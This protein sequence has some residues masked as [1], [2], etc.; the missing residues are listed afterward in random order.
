MASRLT[1][2]LPDP[3]FWRGRKVLVTGHTGFKGAW[4]AF[5]LQRLGAQVTGFALAPESPSLAEAARIESRM[6]SLRGDITDRATLA[7]A[8]ADAEPEIVLHLAAQSLVRRSYREPVETFSTNVMGTAFVL[9]ATRAAPHVQAVLCV[10]SDKCY[11]TS[12]AVQ[13]FREGDALGGDDPYSASKAA[14]EILVAAWRR[15][16]FAAAPDGATSPAIATARAGNVIGGGDWAEDRLVPDC[17]RGFA[18]R[19]SVAIRNPGALRPWQHVLEPLC[20]YLLLTEALCREPARFA[21]AWNFGPSPEMLQPVRYLVERLSQAWGG[22]TWHVAEGAHPH[23]AAMLAVD[24]A[25]AAESLAWRQRLDL[26]TALDWTGRFYRGLSE[27]ADAARLMTAE[28]ERYE[29]LAG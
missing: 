3:E 12:A 9:E 11:D 13:P 14:A 1:G 16:F 26:D 25:R 2:A 6:R 7:A 10:T 24:S 29:S 4:L 15:S 27:G 19:Q 22:G 5:W 28:I 23:E 20:G 21:Q 18:K 17:M 8:F